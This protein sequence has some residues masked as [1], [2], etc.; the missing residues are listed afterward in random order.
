MVEQELLG[1]D[2][3]PDDVFKGH[4]WIV[5]VFFEVGQGDLQFFRI[6]FTA[7]D[8]AIQF[9]DLDVGWP[10]LVVDKLG[11][12]TVAISDLALHFTAVQQVQTLGK[13]GFL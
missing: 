13:V 2:Q 9:L 11:G 8:P 3:C 12:T 6:G 10:V 1:I 7:V 5:L 4:L